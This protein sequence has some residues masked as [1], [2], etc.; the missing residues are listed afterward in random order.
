[1]TN[2]ESTDCWRDNRLDIF[3]QKVFRYA[4]TKCFRYARMLQD[5]RTLQIAAAMQ[6]AG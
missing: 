5:K 3:S 4:L 1:M 2:Y 6:S